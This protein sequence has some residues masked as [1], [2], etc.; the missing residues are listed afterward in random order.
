[1]NSMITFYSFRYTVDELIA[2]PYL[3]HLRKLSNNPQVLAIDMAKLLQFYERKHSTN[4]ELPI[5]GKAE[6]QE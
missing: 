3:K 4:T 5:F 2:H 6:K 1:M